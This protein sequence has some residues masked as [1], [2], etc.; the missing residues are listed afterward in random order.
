MD[1][2]GFMERF[3]NKQVDF[4]FHGRS[5]KFD[6]S[7]S[8]FSSH[9]IDD[10]SRILLKSIARHA[11]VDQLG[12]VLDVGCGVGVLGICLKKRNPALDASFQDRDS[13]ALAFTARNA[14]L[15]QVGRVDIH[16]SLALQGITGKRFDLIVSNLPGKA[17]QPVL[18]NIVRRMPRFLSDTGRAAVVIVRPLADLI[19]RAL[20]ENGSEITLKENGKGYSVFHFHGGRPDEEPEDPLRPYARGTFI[21]KAAQSQL[22]LQTVYN[23]AE[24]DTPGYH[25]LLAINTLKGREVKGRILL[26]K[27]GQGLLATM[28]AQSSREQITELVIAGRDLLSLSI[29]QRNLIE[30]GIVPEIITTAHL[31]HFLSVEGQYDFLILFP[32]MDPGVPWHQ[33]LLPKCDELLADGGQVLLTARST[34]MHRIMSNNPGLVKEAGKRRHGFRSFL[35]RKPAT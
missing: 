31:P 26:W 18:T 25:T 6:L 16:G 30:H 35:L 13:L 23:V 2:T 15:N 7:Q 12:S 19:E 29:S 27:P 1:E 8:L 32:D 9:D 11:A 14:A 17:G 5:L 4:R 28:L 3:I 22:E 34:Y 24:F 20:L 33:V 10:G 21:F